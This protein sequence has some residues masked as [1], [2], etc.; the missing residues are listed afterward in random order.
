MS[1]QRMHFQHTFSVMYA[2]CGV[3]GDN[4]IGP[5][6]L[7]RRLTGQVYSSYIFCKKPAHRLEGF[8]YE[9]RSEMWFIYDRAP[10]YFSNDIK[11]HLNNTCS[12]QWI[13]WNR[14]V[15]WPPRSPD[16]MQSNFF[17]WGWMNCNKLFILNGLTHLR[18]KGTA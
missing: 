5:F 13:G 11:D 18:N 1:L 15:K 4:M 8:P 14:L 7:P 3:L 16:L 2:W 9:N 10:T 6:F 17:L 12:R